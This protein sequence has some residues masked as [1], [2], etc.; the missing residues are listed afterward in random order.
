MPLPSLAALIGIRL[1]EV[2]NRIVRLTDLPRFRGLELGEALCA[3]GSSQRRF[4]LLDGFL[5]GRFADAGEQ[6]RE[7]AWAINR[8]GR[9]FAP[10]S[11]VVAREVGWSRRHFAR[12]F[13]EATGFSP[14]RFRRVSR[15]ERF[16]GSVAL[17]PTATMASLAAEVGYFDEAHLARDVREFSDMTPHELRARFNR[18]A[19]GIR[20]N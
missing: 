14:G 3:A 2:S 17:E 5:K 9:A 18:L 7:L 20:D 15:F 4:D 16:A 10:T 19:G 12:Q 11:S 1:A 13:L 6:R 8:L